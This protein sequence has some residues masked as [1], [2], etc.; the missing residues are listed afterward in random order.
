MLIL[1]SKRPVAAAI[2]VVLS[3]FLFICCVVAAEDAATPPA[4]DLS[5][6]ALRKLSIKELK[7]L[8]WE[9]DIRCEGCTQKEDLI[10]YLVH[11][12]NRPVIRVRGADG[13]IKKT[14][15]EPAPN[16]DEAVESMLNDMSG[17]KND[18]HPDDKEAREK[19]TGY[20]AFW[21]K[22]ATKACK[23][24]PSEPAKFKCAEFAEAV[25]GALGSMVNGMAG[26]L[27]KSASKVDAVSRRSPYVQAGERAL[28]KA[29]RGLSEAK[30]ET[31]NDSSMRGVISSAMSQWWLNVIMENPTQMFD[32]GDGGNM[33]E[34]LRAFRDKHDDEL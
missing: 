19:Q 14:A 5:S 34:V 1:L 3:V 9:R 23:A 25:V 13:N 24:L 10:E 11:N 26:M 7:N 20:A 2:V 16:P 32:L 18:E 29:L 4:P 27:G 8:L 21:R 30:E 22:K 6:A 17:T 31:H 12:T 33:E 28:K 15:A